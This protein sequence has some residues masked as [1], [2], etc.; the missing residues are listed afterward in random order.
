MMV[1]CFCGNT[2]VAVAGEAICPMCRA[3]AA[4]PRL[5]RQDELEMEA[6]LRRLLSEHGQGRG[7]V[8]PD[9]TR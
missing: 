6:S 9:T 3:V 8:G 1:A 2:Y 5:S 4:L 7:Y